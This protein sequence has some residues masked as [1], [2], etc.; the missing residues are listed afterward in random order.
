MGKCDF[1]TA[2]RSTPEV[3]DGY[4][5]GL[6]AIKNADRGKIT[7]SDTSLI[8]GSLDIDSQVK[9]LYPHAPRWDYVLSYS[10][11]LY[12]FEVHPAETS[13][14]DKVISKVKW[15]RGWLNTK[16]PELE[17]LPKSEQPYT[18]V[19]SGRYS[20]IRTSKEQFKLSQAGI[21][22]SKVLN[23]K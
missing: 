17:K 22:T 10:G 8:E 9:S 18:W 7:A 11:R 20:I 15:L 16:A 3:K 6:Q 4:C 5:K 19:Q 12:F 1:E 21:V 14:I 13:E 23:L 2:V